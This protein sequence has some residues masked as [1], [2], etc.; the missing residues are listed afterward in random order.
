MTS[1]VA[2]LSLSHIE[3]LAVQKI[4]QIAVKSARRLGWGIGN[5]AAIV[6][7]RGEMIDSRF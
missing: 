3:P 1:A 6:L 7:L 5:R 2:L 4:L